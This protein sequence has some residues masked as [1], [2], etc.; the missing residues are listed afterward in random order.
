MESSSWK[1]LTPPCGQCDCVGHG[2][3]KWQSECRF[4]RRI[5]EDTVVYYESR[6]REL[7]IRLI[8][9]GRS[10]DFFFPG[11]IRNYILKWRIFARS[12]TLPR[13]LSMPS[14]RPPCNFVDQTRDV[15]KRFSVLSCSEASPELMK[16][17]I[18]QVI[19]SGFLNRPWAELHTGG[20]IILSASR[21]ND[22]QIPNLFA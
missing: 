15:S 19:L 4:L 6:K 8:S 2:A 13:A 5:R 20:I 3:K 12:V 1:R 16:S 17:L 18:L 11:F 7:K 10:R 22:C 14:V 21:R 9:E